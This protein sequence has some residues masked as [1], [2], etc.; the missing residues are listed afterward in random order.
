MA[1][2][3]N[4]NNDL[5]DADLINGCISGDEKHQELLY[6]RFFSFAMSISIRYAKGKDE[7]IEIVNDSFLK[8]LDS[9]STYDQSKPFKTWYAKIL[10][11]TA[12][13]S[14]R[15]KSKS[16]AMLTIGLT[17][18]KEEQTPIISNDLSVGDILKLFDDLPDNL[19]V[20]F[21]LYEIEGYTH[22]E[23]GQMMG[24]TASSS[25]SN[26][27]RAK[28]MLRTLYTKHFNTDK[29]SNEAV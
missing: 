21:N 3:R 20:T 2:K 24:I 4:N 11:N 6:K 19:R 22:E 1:W 8:V 18:E 26:L 15:K 10:V 16:N 27:T 25:R 14:F 23:I 9:F 12:I 5:S 29:K 28:K 7:A 13:D 17:D